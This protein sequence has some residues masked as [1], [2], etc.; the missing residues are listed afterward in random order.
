M[1]T[2]TR[3]YRNRLTPP[4]K[5]KKV[6]DLIKAKPLITPGIQ[7]NHSLITAPAIYGH[8]Q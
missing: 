2:Q 6:L 5:Q 8:P 3:K 4:E 7:V 1:H